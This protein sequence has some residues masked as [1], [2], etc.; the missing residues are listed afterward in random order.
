MSLALG[1][2]LL[3]GRPAA[4][5]AGL[6]PGLGAKDSIHRLQRA[7]VYVVLRGIPRVAVGLPTAADRR[8]GDGWGSSPVLILVRS[9][10]RGPLVLQGERIDGRGALRF[11]PGENP[12]DQ[13]SLPAGAWRSQRGL[14]RRWG[15]ELT[16]TTRWRAWTTT[17]RTETA[18]CYGIQLDGRTFSY[19]VVLR[20]GQ[21]G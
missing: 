8:L 1:A 2:G 12:S 6:G 9:S 13:L 15:I 4:P 17:L 11:G 7:P 10:Y 14:V 18:G 16:R 20:V 21:S 5:E 3:P 19:D